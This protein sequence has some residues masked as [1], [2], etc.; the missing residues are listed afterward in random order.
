MV[1]F[2][3]G[4]NDHYNNNPDFDYYGENRYQY[5]KNRLQ[6]SPPLSAGSITVYYG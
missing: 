4:A 6:K 5:W 3:D 2:F 1:I